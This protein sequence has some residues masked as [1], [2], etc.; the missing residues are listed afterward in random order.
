V[1]R[2]NYSLDGEFFFEGHLHVVH[3][4]NYDLDTFIIVSERGRILECSDN[5]FGSSE[6]GRTI[7]NIE[8]Y[9]DV[10]TVGLP[11]TRCT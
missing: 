10:K 1:L 9:F 5:I 11:L 4:D 2:L 3:A 8:R 7:L 6:N